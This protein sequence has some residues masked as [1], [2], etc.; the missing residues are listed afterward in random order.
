MRSLHGGSALT[1]TQQR[2]IDQRQNANRTDERADDNGGEVSRRQTL[3]LAAV[4]G[5]RRGD[6]GELDGDRGHGGGGET[7]RAFARRRALQ[8]RLEGA[9]VHGSHQRG[10]QRRVHRRG[11]R[12]AVALCT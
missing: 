2:E 8:R 4:T 11:V 6:V 10:L 12:R 3:A 5:R 9:A 1:S 7:A